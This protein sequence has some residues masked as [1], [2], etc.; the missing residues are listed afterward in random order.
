MSHLVTPPLF[1]SGVSALPEPLT[2]AMEESEL[3]AADILC[4]YPRSAPELLGR[5]PMVSLIMDGC[6]VHQSE[7]FA[8]VLSSSVGTL[9]FDPEACRGGRVGLA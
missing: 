3:C 7:H 6:E 4:S 5:I 2:D 1:S 9:T 8:K